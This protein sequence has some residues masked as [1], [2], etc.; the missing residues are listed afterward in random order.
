M[1][2][3]LNLTL[4]SRQAVYILGFILY[5]LYCLVCIHRL[6]MVQIKWH[7]CLPL[8]LWCDPVQSA[9][10]SRYCEFSHIVRCAFADCSVDKRN[11]GSCLGAFDSVFGYR[12]HG[13][14]S[15]SVS[16][17]YHS[18]WNPRPT[19]AS[20]ISTSWSS[21]STKSAWSLVWFCTGSPVKPIKR[22][23]G[24]THWATEQHVLCLVFGHNWRILLWM[25]LDLCRPW[26][27]RS[28]R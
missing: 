2:M 11:G 16:Q 1:K 26:S 14:G 24:R 5:W 7:P 28:A 27:R 23:W 18:E 10:S 19:P 25:H 22:A 20:P 3:P 17:E 4:M 15:F 6:W 9:L 13:F 8:S 21:L 12:S